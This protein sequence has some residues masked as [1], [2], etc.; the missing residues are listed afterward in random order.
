MKPTRT[1]Y[2]A[3]T[4]FESCPKSYALYYLEGHKTEA[5][6]AAN[7]G[8]RLHTA[9]ERFLKG[10]IELQQLSIDFFQ[11]KAQLH[12][13]KEC[14]AKS[15]EVWLLSDD[16]WALQEVEDDT[17]RFKSIVDIHYVI[18][19]TLF[20]RDLKS[21]RRYPEHD[22]QLQGYALVGFHRYPEVTQVDVAALYL[23]GPA[24]SMVYPR[25]MLP[26]LQTF[27]KGRWDIVLGAEEYP[28][29]PSQDACRYCK[30]PKMGLCDVGV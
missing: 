10:E 29:T 5:G 30:Y 16:P 9:C 19:E 11:I 13:M 23:E 22:D 3:M 17:T 15:E 8:T 28:A 4:T 26:H 14:G 25:A 7:R 20:I 2:S 27:W 21:G 18:G 24:P 12:I 1:S 6:A